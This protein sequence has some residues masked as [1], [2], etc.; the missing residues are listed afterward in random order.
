MITRIDDDVTKR[1][2]NVKTKNKRHYNDQLERVYAVTKI[3]NAKEGVDLNQHNP[4]AEKILDR[5]SVRV[6]KD[7]TD[8]LYFR[9]ERGVSDE[10][11]KS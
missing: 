2:R 11:C 6:L 10:M 4:I 5:S 9:S 3:I 8:V 1:L 7:G